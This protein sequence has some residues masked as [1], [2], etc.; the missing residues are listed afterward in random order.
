MPAYQHEGVVARFPDAAV[1]LS[2]SA[3]LTNSGTFHVKVTPGSR[4]ELFALLSPEYSIQLATDNN[5]VRF[6][7]NAHVVE[8]VIGAVSR[9]Y[10]VLVSWKPDKM[11]VAIMIDD[12]L[13]GEDACVSLDT[14]PLYVPIRLLD[15][16]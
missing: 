11:Q 15:W 9:Y 7:R 13:G 16:A 10:Q 1:G 2:V 12:D 3:L 6:S 4:G 8:K 14:Q 5:R